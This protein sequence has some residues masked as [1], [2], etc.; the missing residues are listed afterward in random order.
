MLYIKNNGLNYC[1]RF[2]YSDGHIYVDEASA[3]SPEALISFIG[4]DRHSGPCEF[5]NLDD[6]LTLIYEKLDDYELSKN[7]VVEVQIYNKN[8]EEITHSKKF[9]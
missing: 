2:V 1:L 7:K 5:D 6:M 9:K 4:Y 8:T 3:I